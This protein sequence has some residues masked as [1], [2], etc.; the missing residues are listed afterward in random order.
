MRNES[1]RN[2]QKEADPFFTLF[3]LFFRFLPLSLQP[4]EQRQRGRNSEES[5]AR[6]GSVGAG[7]GA[8]AA[9]VDMPGE[10]MRATKPNCLAISHFSSFPCSQFALAALPPKQSSPLDIPT[11]AG[12]PARN[13]GGERA[14]GGDK[15]A[16]KAKKIDKS[17][18]GSGLC[19]FVFVVRVQRCLCSCA[20]SAAVVS[21][22]GK[23]RLANGLI[24]AA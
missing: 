3:V 23:K 6:H 15:N 13:A 24:L 17:G 11:Y 21:V 8:G 5:S 1:G 22:A 4:E 18:C 7:A 14:F 10:S 9:A 12:Q 16:R 19:V 2:T 20:A